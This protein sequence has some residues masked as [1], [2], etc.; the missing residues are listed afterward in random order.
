MAAMRIALANRLNLRATAPAR[1]VPKDRPASRGRL[2]GSEHG[3][4]FAELYRQHF[5]RVFAYVYGRVQDKEISLDIV[6]DVFEKVDKAIGE[7]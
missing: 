5:P 1:A 4:E 6:A 2:D 7:R 3:G